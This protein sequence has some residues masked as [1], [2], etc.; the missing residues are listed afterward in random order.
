M[1]ALLGPLVAC[2]LLAWPFALRAEQVDSLVADT[3]VGVLEH[4]A[5]AAPE[6]RHFDAQ[7]IADLQADPANDYLGDPERPPTPWER[8]LAWLQ[9]QLDRTMGTGPASWF[10][11]NLWVFLIILAVLI[12][13]FT[14]R[15][16]LFTGAFS[17]APTR[18]PEVG[19][20]HAEVQ[21]DDLDERIRAAEQ[22]G[23]WR[24][25]LRLYYLLSLRKLADTGHITLGP[26]ATDR[27]YLYQVADSGLRERFRSLAGTFQWVW[28]G[29][30][31]VDRARYETLIADFRRF[32]PP[33][34][35]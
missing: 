9:R 27:D 24:K 18:L 15:K 6:I 23:A 32:D 1:R 13:A 16:R 20:L 3:A 28:Y 30:A 22:E 33:P 19:E 7:A 4:R 17:K 35:A 31:S 34:R 25:A 5:P 21:A 10:M 26:Q 8:F 11:R 12:A 29:D 14:L 2:L